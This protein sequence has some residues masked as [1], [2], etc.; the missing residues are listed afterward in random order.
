MTLVMKTLLVL[1]QEYSSCIMSVAQWKGR[2][3]KLSRLQRAHGT[4]QK[5]CPTETQLNDV[6]W[7]MCVSLQSLL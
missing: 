6:G 5:M 3:G 4:S 2:A 7:Y 1:E